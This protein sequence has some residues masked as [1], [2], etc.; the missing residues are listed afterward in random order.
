MKKDGEGQVDGQPTGEPREAAA[1][2]QRTRRTML[3]AAMLGI[4]TVITV[5][6]RPAKAQTSG[7]SADPYG[8]G[9]P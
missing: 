6:S 8:Y 9:N 4:P 2:R 7:G 3:R 1:R 5:R